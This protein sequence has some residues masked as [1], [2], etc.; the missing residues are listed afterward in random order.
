M[1]TTE[2]RRFYFP[3]FTLLSPLHPAFSPSPYFLP[4]TS[5]SILQFLPSPPSFFLNPQPSLHQLCPK[6]LPSG[7]PDI[8]KPLT[9]GLLNEEKEKINLTH[10][11]SPP[12]LPPLSPKVDYFP[13]FLPAASTA[14]TDPQLWIFSWRKPTPAKSRPMRSLN[15][16]VAAPSVATSPRRR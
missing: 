4:F 11:P 5:P 9:Q 10:P 3:L 13:S 7:V 1:N 8:S 16:G 2:Y 6:N 14:L 15:P 12:T